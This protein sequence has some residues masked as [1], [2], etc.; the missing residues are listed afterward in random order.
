MPVPEEG[1]AL[2]EEETKPWRGMCLSAVDTH[3]RVGLVPAAS[4]C[5]PGH[6]P[7]QRTSF[8][9]R[10]RGVPSSPS[11]PGLTALL[12]GERLVC[13]G[14]RWELPG[15]GTQQEAHVPAVQ[16]VASGLGV[17]ISKITLGPRVGRWCHV[18]GP[19]PGPQ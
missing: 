11:L 8:E 12:H 10:N 9:E 7:T 1:T 6:R 14:L 15:L 16:S 13:I 19:P 17:I 5:H 2:S 3:L 18:R 4:L